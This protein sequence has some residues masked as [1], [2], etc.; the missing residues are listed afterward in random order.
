MENA[1]ARAK[2]DA[3]QNKLFVNTTAQLS[4]FT[5]NHL[6]FDAATSATNRWNN[7]KRAICIATVLHLDDG[8]RAPTRAQMHGRLQLSFKED[9]AAQDLCA[10][11]GAKVLIEH[12]RCN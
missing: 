8:A 9:A 2:R 5:K 11:V 4:N 7:A 6:R 12:I 1:A 3:Q 10:A